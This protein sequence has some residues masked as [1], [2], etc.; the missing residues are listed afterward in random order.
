M[1]G[2]GREC[3]EQ[4]EQDMRRT[5]LTREDDDECNNEKKNKANRTFAKTQSGCR[6]RYAIEQTR[7]RIRPYKTLLEDIFQRMEDFTSF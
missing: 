6:H 2:R 3:R 5:E 7:K 1:Y 4:N